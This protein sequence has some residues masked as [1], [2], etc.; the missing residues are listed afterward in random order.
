MELR[1]RTALVTGGG[2]RVGRALTLA[3]ARAGADVLIHYRGSAAQ[4]ER[5][6]EEVRALGRRAATVRADLAD[7]RSAA[8]VADA[9]RR[10]LGGLDVL[11]NSAATFARAPVEEI[12]AEEWDHVMAVNVRAPFLLAQRLAPLLRA[13]DGGVIV[14]IADLSAFQPWPTYAH[15][16][17]SKAGLLHLTAVLARAL[18]P[19]VRVNCIAPG[20]VLPAEDPVHVGN[21]VERRLVPR[22]GTPE[23]VARTLIFLI[24]SDYITGETVVVDGGRKWL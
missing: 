5:T 23:D 19:G 14:N 24:E 22:A 3:L 12:T 17:V 10:E 21:G 1:D 11:V 20:T 2:V 15:H 4:A 13:G 16:A 18:A 6:A 8:V 9:V 7:A